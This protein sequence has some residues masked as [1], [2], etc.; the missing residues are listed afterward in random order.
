MHGVEDRIQTKPEKR[1]VPTYEVDGIYH[2]VADLQLNIS[3]EAFLASKSGKYQIS[4][5]V[6][7]TNYE[8][9]VVPATYTLTGYYKVYYQLS[10]GTVYTE[11]VEEGKNPVGVTKE[12][13]GVPRFS[14]ISYSEDYL[15][16]GSDIYVEV[17][18]KDYSAI[19]YTGI[20]FVVGAV[21]IFIIY[22]K[23]RESSV[24]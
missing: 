21:I 6:G 2:S 8:V 5:V 9:E 16:N 18:Y 10:N 22:W 14:K 17:D 11:R 1:A 13:L 12:Q 7:N 19:I 24:R 4:C 15:V 3:T 23:K 20:I